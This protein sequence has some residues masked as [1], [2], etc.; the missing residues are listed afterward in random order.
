M[1]SSQALR[2]G[3]RGED[4]DRFLDRF[5]QAELDSLELEL[6]GLDLREIQNVVDDLQQAPRR[7]ARSF[8]TDAAAAA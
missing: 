5:A 6:A 2:V 8:P 3:A 7:N 4:L 1:R